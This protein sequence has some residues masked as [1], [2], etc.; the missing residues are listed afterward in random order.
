[1]LYV[2]PI[3]LS[4]PKLVL[5]GM[6]V[7]V[8]VYGSLTQS[9]FLLAQLL[10]FGSMI[11]YR[12][13]RRNLKETLRLFYSKY[14]WGHPR[15]SYFAVYTKASRDDDRHYSP[16]IFVVKQVAILDK[17]PVFRFNEHL[18]KAENHKATRIS[19]GEVMRLVGVQDM[20]QHLVQGLSSE[21]IR[22]SEA[23]FGKQ[24]QVAPPTLTSLVMRHVDYDND[25]FV[26]SLNSMFFTRSV[27]SPAPI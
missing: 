22:R 15:A 25:W 7:L 3:G 17:C 23:I 19:A 5:G 2:Q 1:V 13:V 9:L 11:F 6:L 8:L 27:S 21:G 26:L 16:R 14:E 10:I 4:I 20:R 24:Q 12:S 18:Y